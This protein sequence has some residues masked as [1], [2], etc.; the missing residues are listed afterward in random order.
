MDCVQDLQSKYNPGI[1]IYMNEDKYAEWDIEE[2]DT[3]HR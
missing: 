1:N 2:W 3:Y